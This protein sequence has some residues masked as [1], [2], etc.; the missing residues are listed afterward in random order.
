MIPAFDFSTM[1]GVFDRYVAERLPLLAPGTQRQTLG[2]L[3]VRVV[4]TENNSTVRR[5]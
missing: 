5:D 1:N 2:H 4:R 3:K